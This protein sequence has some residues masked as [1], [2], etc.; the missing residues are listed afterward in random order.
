M[1]DLII[2]NILRYGARAIFVRTIKKF[3]D[4]TT[5]LREAQERAL[6]K[7]IEKNKDTL[8]GREFGFSNIKG[9]EDFQKFVPLND[10]TT[11]E[12]YIEKMIMGEENI[13]TPDEIIFFG[14]TSGTTAKPKFIPITDEHF[15]YVGRSVL[16]YFRFITEE[17]PQAI[18]GGTIK[19]TSPKLEGFTEK[20]V[21]YGS[22]WYITE[23]AKN[24]RNPIL[25]D[26]LIALNKNYWE[27]EI[28]NITDFNTK[29]YIIMRLAVE[30]NITHF[31]MANP[32]TVLLFA[33]K[34]NEFAE[35]I[36]RDLYDGSIKKGLFLDPALRM[37]LIRKI[38]RNARRA[39]ELERL[40]QGD[41]MLK[42]SKVFKNLSLISCWKGGSAGFYIKQ[43]PKYFENTPTMEYGIG[44]TEGIFA[45]P[46]RL[47]ERGCI[48]QPGY[49]FFEFIPEEEYFSERKRILTADQLELGGRYSI[50]ITGY[51]GLY[52]YDMKDIV[53][54]VGF[55]NKSPII[56]F[57]HKA[58]N[59]VSYTGEKI[60]ET[61]ITEA[62]NQTIS[63]SFIHLNGFTFLPDESGE[64]PRYIL[65]IEPQEQIGDDMA[66]GFL[67]A[68]EKNL[69]KVNMEYETKRVSMRLGAPLLA[70]LKNGEYERFRAALIAKG[71]SDATTKPPVLKKE[72]SFIDN[73]NVIRKYEYK[74]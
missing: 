4:D 48:L 57:L 5:H 38:K 14:T 10:Y 53:E 31:S 46:Y 20:G 15:K 42:P 58:G 61:H 36:I 74:E 8:Y 21:P 24:R 9:I 70:V 16:P 68:F 25:R 33:K 71:A 73:F 11:L 32:S 65:M 54:V 62:I 35:D 72:P 64:L 17:C 3:E 55:Y 30:R 63:E 22:P 51:N 18:R 34:L 50:V 23:V 12:P 27:D 6:K 60:F 67:R 1:K 13:L 41:G 66:E 19:M 7:I 69:R 43:F 59:A 40:L 47:E 39:K 49:I 37:K 29:Y 56:A 26:L 45:I 52:R 44:A 2:N 28:F